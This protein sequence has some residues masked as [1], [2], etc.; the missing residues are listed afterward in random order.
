MP[1]SLTVEHKDREHSAHG[2]SIAA[3]FFACPGSIRASEGI[4]NKTNSAAEEGTAAHELGEICLREGCSAFEYLGL[5]VHDHEV[6]DKMATTVQ[7]YLDECRLYMGPGWEWWIESRVRLDLLNPPVPLFGTTDFAAYNRKLRKL[8]I[9]DLKNGYVAVNIKG[10]L[11]VRYYAL[12]TYLSLPADYEVDEIELVVVQPND[13]RNPAPKRDYT[14]IIDLMDFGMLLVEK[15][16]ETLEPDAPLHAGP[17]CKYCPK[18][19]KC[20]A[21]AKLTTDTLGMEFAAF[22][23]PIKPTEVEVLSCTRDMATFTPEDLENIAIKAPFIRQF[24]SDVEAVLKGMSERGY[25]GTLTELVDTEGNRTWTKD[26]SPDFIAGLL[27][28]GEFGLTKDAVYTKPKLGSPAQ[29]ESAF[30]AKQ[31]MN[32]MKK[33]KA[34]DLFKE[35]SANNGLVYRPVSTKLMPK[36]ANR[37]PKSL[38]TPDDYGFTFEPA[39][40]EGD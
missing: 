17:H 2:A 29:V 15:C 30:V 14:T 35:L 25:K 20:P 34:E 19:G 5:T 22:M 23:E 3:R 13:F 7:K 40:I 6:T 26:H 11:Q 32:G 33:K 12:G 1:D 37:K 38:R 8:V 39:P 24:L 10:N 28:Q 9:V 18:T 36:D 21:Q 31:I 16:Y 4:E 27:T